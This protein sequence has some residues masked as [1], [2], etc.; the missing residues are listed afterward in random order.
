MMAQ[1]SALFPLSRLLCHIFYPIMVPLSSIFHEKNGCLFEPIL[2][3]RVSI[4]NIK[5][6]KS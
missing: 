2:F 4:S 1:S 3:P 5:N 6:L